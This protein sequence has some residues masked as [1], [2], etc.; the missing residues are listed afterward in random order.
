MCYFDELTKEEIARRLGIQEERV[1]L[2]K[3]RALQQL[4]VVYKKMIGG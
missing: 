2:V 3:S 1:R 4:K